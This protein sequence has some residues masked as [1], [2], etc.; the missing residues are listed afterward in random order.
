MVWCSRS[1]L[2]VLR[3]IA[4]PV[5]VNVISFFLR[6]FHRKVFYSSPLMSHKRKH[7]VSGLKGGGRMRRVD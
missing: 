4:D 3:K 7:K 6:S 5:L 1:Y 2:R